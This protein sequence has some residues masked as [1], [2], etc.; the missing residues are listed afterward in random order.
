MKFAKSIMLLGFLLVQGC[1]EPADNS[2]EVARTES[3]PHAASAA[4]AG[5]KALETG[6]RIYDHY[7]LPCHAAGPGHPG[8]MRLAIRL[9]EER[10]VLL[11]RADLPAQYVM[12]IVRQGLNLMPGFRPSEIDD[13]ELEALTH[14]MSNES[15]G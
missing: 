12:A 10:S 6:K 15:R 11:E 1:S 8:T 9:G 14:Y 7:C 3:D 2:V 13:A 5:P 4:P